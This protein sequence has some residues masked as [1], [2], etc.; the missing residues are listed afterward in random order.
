[1]Q[2]GRRRFL[3]LAT[4]LAA[5]PLA[6]A[7]APEASAVTA[8]LRHYARLVHSSYAD[9]LSQAR[10]LQ[11]S[12]RRFLA[13]PDEAALARARAAWIAA[14]ECYGQTEAFRFYGGPIDAADGPEPRIN[15]WPV[16]E[17]FIDA[18]RGRPEAGLIQQRGLPLDRATLIRLNTFDG[19]E[20]IA[21]GWHAIEFLL[22]GQ[23]FSAS[24]PGERPAR[25]FLDGQAPNAD[26]RRRYLALVTE[27]LV[28]DLAGLVA[29]W[30]P[31]RANYRRRFE[32]MGS[33]GLRAILIGLGSLASAELAGE[34][35]QVALA[36]REQ[37]DEQSCFSDNTH[38]DIVADALG[39]QNVWLGRYQ[40]LQG[41]LLQGP[42]LRDL[43]A[44]RDIALAERLSAALAEA[45]AAAEAIQPPFDR[46][47]LGGADAPGRQRLQRVV[48]ALLRTTGLL[49]EAARL[50]GINKLSWVRK[51]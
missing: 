16:D 19:E 3:L 9:T 17:S 25:D 23:D 4:A 13:A 18:V 5:V 7:D 39:L 32:A 10:L 35:L 37:E 36:S 27:L 40:P 24:G 38:R 31:G 1:M 42:A 30:A 48:T 12:V 8:V 28:D 6:R 33:E 15:A 22:W 26:R 45:L 34:R 29:A 2:E 50:L 41:A 44:L 43:V 11:R 46:E 20:N 47:I 14:R 49:V 51:A 21:T